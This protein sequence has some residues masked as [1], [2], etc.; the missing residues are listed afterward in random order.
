MKDKHAPNWM[1]ISLVVV[2]AVAAGVSFYHIVRL[3]L[4]YRQPIGAA[5]PLPFSVDG[6]IVACSI[7][8]YRSARAE[9]RGLWIATLGVWSGIAGTLAANVGYGI[10]ANEGYGL[11][12]EIVGSIVSG[13]P[14]YAF[15]VTV[16]VT[17][18]S[19]RRT[20]KRDRKRA[21]VAAPAREVLGVL[22]DRQRATAAPVVAEPVVAEPAQDAAA[23]V[24]T[25][26]HRG[27]RADAPVLRATG[28]KRGTEPAGYDDAVQYVREL[29]AAGQQAP[30]A[31]FLAEHYL[32]GN[33]HAAGRAVAAG[34]NGHALPAAE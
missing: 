33:R 21:T 17:I 18:M 9:G 19:A 26:G 1:T 8:R 3:A 15:L 34:L 7:A 5:L 11:P 13:W 29:I 16:E 32:G 22:D 12:H 2:A 4:D 23:P 31:R 24:L 25:P 14:S 20:A 6:L 10:T 30:S 27:A 28:R